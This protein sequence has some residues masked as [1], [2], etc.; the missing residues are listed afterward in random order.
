[1]NDTEN[2]PVVPATGERCARPCALKSCC[3]WLSIASRL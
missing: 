2:D 3:H 1:M